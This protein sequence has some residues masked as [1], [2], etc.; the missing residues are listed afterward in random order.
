VEIVS[1]REAARRLG[2][3]NRTI[4]DVVRKAGIAT[5]PHPSNGAAFGLTTKQLAEI[6]R[7]LEPRRSQTA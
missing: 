4:A 6:K 2:V 7:R 3:D 5:V 1:F